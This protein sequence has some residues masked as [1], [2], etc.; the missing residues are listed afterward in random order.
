[1]NIEIPK[2]VLKITRPIVNIGSV[3]YKL[4][5]MSTLVTLSLGG[6]F[7]P[8]VAGI[9]LTTLGLHLVGRLSRILNIY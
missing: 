8:V 1:M 2:K 7:P 4:F 3:L 5:A 6:F 9:L